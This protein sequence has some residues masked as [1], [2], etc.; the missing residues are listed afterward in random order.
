MYNYAKSSVQIYRDWRIEIGVPKIF[1]S[2]FLRL[3]I[4]SQIL[5]LTIINRF[6]LEV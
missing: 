3:P 4:A 5:L 2:S 1:E 6:V